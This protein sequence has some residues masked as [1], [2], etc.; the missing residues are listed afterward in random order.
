MKKSILKLRFEYFIVFFLIMVS[1]NPMLDSRGR[2]EIILVV[3]FVLCLIYGNVLKKIVFN[4]Y[5]ALFFALFFVLITIQVFEFNLFSFRTFAGFYI[6]IFLGFVVFYAI[7]S[8]SEKYIKCLYWICAIS[9]IFYIPSEILRIGFGVNLRS[10]FEPLKF[11]SG[12][13]NILHVIFY[14]FDG[15]GEP[16]R[17]SGPFWE[18]GAF[19]GYILIAI[20]LLSA[21]KNRMLPRDYWKTLI[22][23][24]LTLLSTKSTT[25]YLLLPLAL[26]SHLNFNVDPRLLPFFMLK[27]AVIVFIGI[28]FAPKIMEI[29]FLKEKITHQYKEAINEQPGFETNRFGNFLSDWKDIRKKPLLG[30]GIF[31]KP[32]NVVSESIRNSQGNGLSASLY[33]FGF[34]GFG[35]YF[36]YLFFSLRRFYSGSKMHISV[37]LFVI[38][39]SLNG[40]A[41]LNFPIYW[42]LIALP[43]S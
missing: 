16:N 5:L 21:Y 22:V 34:I 17:N 31:E 2:L 7:P 19:Q 18:P 25:G 8:G 40:E 9:L 42:G 15:A 24:I 29:D 33:R 26:I 1:G 4:Q 36:I 20:L 30:F 35:L 6:R 3:T 14:N 32:S 37:A 39:F 12:D 11:I 38:L 10:L 27:V 41:F 13:I 43:R 28:L 23:F